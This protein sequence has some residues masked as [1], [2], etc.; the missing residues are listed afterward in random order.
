MCVRV[1]FSSVFCSVL[2]LL[3]TLS[4]KE[5]QWRMGKHVFVTVGTTKFNSLIQAVDDPEVLSTLSCQGYTSL[6]AQIGHGEH[7]PTFATAP[8]SVN[9]ALAPCRRNV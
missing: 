3:S 2:T 6:T 4:R 5:L 9:K 8:Q 7:V 1:L